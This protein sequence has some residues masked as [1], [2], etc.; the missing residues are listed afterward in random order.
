MARPVVSSR[1]LPT[2]AQAQLYAE[3][4]T[5]PEPLARRSVHLCAVNFIVADFECLIKP[6]S[7]NIQAQGS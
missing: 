5:T 2:S 4:A 3:L 7:P 6:V 1:Q